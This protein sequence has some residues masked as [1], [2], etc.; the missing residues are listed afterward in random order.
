LD[1]YLTSKKRVVLVLDETT[2]PPGKADNL[3]PDEIIYVEPEI[4]MTVLV[5][6]VSNVIDVILLLVLL[7]LLLVVVVMVIISIV[8]SVHAV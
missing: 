5:M 1:Y 6:T 3:G 4:E 8:M 7:M 2:G